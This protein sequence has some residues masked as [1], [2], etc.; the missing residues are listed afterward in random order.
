[1]QIE[2]E[3][4]ADSSSVEVYVFTLLDTNL[5]LTE[6]GIKIRPLGKRKFSYK[7][8]YDRIYDRDNKIN[9]SEIIITDEIKE[10]V[11]N[12]YFNLVKVVKHSELKK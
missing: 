1:M 7:K 5:V 6:F 8:L 12:E 9:E 4:N 10:R 2:I 3:I 11:K